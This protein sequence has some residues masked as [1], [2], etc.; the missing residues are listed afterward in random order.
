MGTLQSLRDRT[1]ITGPRSP[2]MRGCPQSQ[3]TPR[4]LWR[5]QEASVLLEGVK[6]TKLIAKSPLRIMDIYESNCGK[7]VHIQ[8]NTI[9][10]ACWDQFYCK[11]IQ[12]IQYSYLYNKLGLGTILIDSNFIMSLWLN[13]SSLIK[14]PSAHFLESKILSNKGLIHQ[15]NL[16]LKHQGWR[17]LINL[18]LFQTLVLIYLCS[19]WLRFSVKRA[20][21]SL[22][23]N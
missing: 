21:S 15:Q 6:L 17:Q 2:G 14:L 18:T 23:D 5:P 9:H 7:G 10:Q 13:I 19:F 12:Y 22:F 8:Y 1:R 11:P 4:S 3:V 20:K 16:S